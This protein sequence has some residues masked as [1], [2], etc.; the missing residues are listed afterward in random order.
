MVLQVVRDNSRARCL[1]VAGE[2]P[3]PPT[4]T[5][6]CSGWGPLKSHAASSGIMC[7]RDGQV[8]ARHPDHCT[9]CQCPHT[10]VH[11][12]IHETK[13]DRVFLKLPYG[14][15]AEA[16]NVR[17]TASQDKVCRHVLMVGGMD[18]IITQSCP[19]LSRFLP[20]KCLSLAYAVAAS[21]G[22]VVKHNV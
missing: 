9:Q 16:V 2:V 20:M 3:V 13:I 7:R 11:V 1:L 14:V 6:V 17:K 18:I 15:Q 21:V 19:C 8:Q 5:T 22:P 12:S 4:Q 10:H